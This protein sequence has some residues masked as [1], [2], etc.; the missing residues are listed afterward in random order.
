MMTA[1]TE[2]NNGRKQW[3]NVYRAFT[4]T[5]PTFRATHETLSMKLQFPILPSFETWLNQHR[6][7]TAQDTTR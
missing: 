1:R 3:V 6:L 5:S 4:A 2:G 7:V